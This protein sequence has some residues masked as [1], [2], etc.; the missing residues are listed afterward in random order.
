MPGAWEK[1]VKKALR[2][3]AE[4][5]VPRVPEVTPKTIKKS[6]KT[7]PRTPLGH[8]W[9]PGVTLSG[10]WLHFG[11]ILVPPN[12]QTG[13]TVVQK[14]SRELPKR[15]DNFGHFLSAMASKTPIREDNGKKKVTM[16]RHTG[17]SQGAGGR[18][19]QPLGSAAPLN[20]V[21]GRVQDN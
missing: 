15:S 1:S 4:T 18:G 21:Q 9:G 19:R 11:S 8:R 2:K 20:G 14:K 16:N 6:S 7:P 13:H 17:P 3:S 10:Y 5:W 12:R